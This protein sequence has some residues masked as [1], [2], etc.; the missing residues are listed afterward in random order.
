MWIRY[1]SPGT[2]FLKGGWC[3][4]L[5]K[6]LS[7]NIDNI[8]S[9]LVTGNLW[10]VQQKSLCA[11]TCNY[12]LPLWI[13]KEKRKERKR[14]PTTP[15]TDQAIRWHYQFSWWRS[16]WIEPLTRHLKL[17][18]QGPGHP[19]LKRINNITLLNDYVPAQSFFNVH[20]HVTG[21]KKLISGDNFLTNM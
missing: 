18:V 9:N 14:M 15:L 13:E 7:T 5:D 16:L 4:P 2:S 8:N 19:D 12:F 3:N 17:S 10:R 21:K 20:V 6:L 11:I 1:Y